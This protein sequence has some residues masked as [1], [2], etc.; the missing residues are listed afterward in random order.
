MIAG[1]LVSC[2][3]VTIACKL[4]DNSRMPLTCTSL[5][6]PVDCC[7]QPN[8]H[9][10]LVAPTPQLAHDMLQHKLCVVCNAH[11]GLGQAMGS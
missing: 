1:Q 8:W 3:M 6:A 11:S 10:L 7:L 4:T 5:H 2:N 9:C